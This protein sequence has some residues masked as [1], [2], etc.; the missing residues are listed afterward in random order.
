MVR[1]V[2]SELLHVV[3]PS[4]VGFLTVTASDAGV[5]RLRWDDTAPE[6][7]SPEARAQGP[8]AES[9]ERE[10]CE[11]FEGTRREFS[12]PLDLTTMSPFHQQVLT[13]LMREVPWGHTTTY[14]Q[15]A[16]MVDAPGSARVIGRVM[17]ENAI[18]I[19]LPCHRVLAANGEMGGFGGGLARKRILLHV[20]RV[21]LFA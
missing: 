7:Y 5:Q 3:V 16:K 15:L 17:H 6:G 20:E 2:G 8:L 13:T 14:G 10:L 9:I 18:P 4:P 19:V 1:L 21:L 11:Y 12:W